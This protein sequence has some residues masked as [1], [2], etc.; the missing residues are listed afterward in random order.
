[1]AKHSTPKRKYTAEF[2]GQP[3]LDDLLRLVS[4]GEPILAVAR[5]MGIAT[6]NRQ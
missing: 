3:A 5:K 6:A 2:N 4:N 1:M